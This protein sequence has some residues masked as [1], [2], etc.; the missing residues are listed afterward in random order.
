MEQE[1]DK[2]KV[3][4]VKQAYESPAVEVIK[5]EVEESV[6]VLVGS[7]TSGGTGRDYPFE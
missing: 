2:Q 4:V 5:M 7:S 3:S 6:A 1:L